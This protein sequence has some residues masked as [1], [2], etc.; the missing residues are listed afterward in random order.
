MKTWKSK[1]TVCRGA[2]SGRFANKGKCKAFKKTKIKT[3]F[4]GALF[5]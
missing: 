2:K 3:H 1:R 5:N 4:F